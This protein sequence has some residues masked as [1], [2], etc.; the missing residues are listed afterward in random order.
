MNA[1]TIEIIAEGLPN[2][3]KLRPDEVA[4]YFDVTDRT[5]YNWCRDGKIVF[6]QLPT[7]IIRIPR[8]AVIEV[9]R[10]SIRNDDCQIGITQKQICRI[11]PSRDIVKTV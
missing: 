1:M 6:E 4:R 9:I 10:A 7:G 2:K 5:V 8:V 11:C 3:P